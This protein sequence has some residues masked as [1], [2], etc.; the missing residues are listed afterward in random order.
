MTKYIKGGPFR[1]FPRKG[2]LAEKALFGREK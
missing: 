2:F 1:F